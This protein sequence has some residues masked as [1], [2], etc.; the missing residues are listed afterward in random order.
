MNLNQIADDVCLYISF[1]LNVEDIR[2]NTR[3][4]EVVDARKIAY[5]ILREKYQL[6]YSSIGK[7]FNKNHATVM[8]NLKSVK[9]LLEYDIIFKE[10]FN[11]CVLNFDEQKSEIKVLLMLRDFKESMD[12]ITETYEMLKKITNFNKNVLKFINT[13]QKYQQQWEKIIQH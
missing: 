5:Y 3:L 2:K 11:D 9:G 8:H 12:Q 1:K 6:S 13:E 7:V 4:A 10:K